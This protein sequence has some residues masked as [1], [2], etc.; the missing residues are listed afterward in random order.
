M[1]LYRISAYPNVSSGA[2]NQT[3]VHYLL[4]GGLTYLS[5]YPPQSTRITWHKCPF[6]GN[7]QN[8]DDKGANCIK[9]GGD[10]L[11]EGVR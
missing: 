5:N 4:D 8:I 1:T 10:V 9:C 7:R 2:Y 11:H 3:G 6:C